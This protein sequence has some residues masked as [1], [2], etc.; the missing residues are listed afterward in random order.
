MP[1]ARWLLLLPFAAPLLY[2]GPAAELAKGIAQAGLDPQSCYRVRDL[3]LAKE[4]LRLYF[5][6]GYLIFGKPIDGDPIT[7]VF[8]TTLQGGDA[9]IMALPPN[10]GERQSLASFTHS[11]NLDEHF[12]LAVMLFTDQTYRD[13]LAQ[14]GD[15][16]S[17][18]KSPEMGLTMAPEWTPVVRNLASSFENRLVLDLLSG[19][20]SSQAFFF[21]AIAG[22]ELGNFDA[23]YDARSSEQITLGHSAWRDERPYFDVWTSFEARAQRNGTRAA[24]KPEFDVDDFR[25][26]A[27]LLPPDLRVQAVT[28]VKV[29]PA[30]G[31]GRVFPFELSRSMRVTAASVDGRPAEIFEAESQR[32]NLIHDRGNGLILLIP[33]QPLTPGREYEFE[34]HHEGAVIAT[35]GNKVYA[36]G[37]RANWYP[38]RGLHFTKFDL[39]FRYPKDLDLVSSGDVVSDVVEGDSRVT[40][41]KV[42]TPV[43]MVGFN[44][45]VYDREKITRGSQTVEV[46]AN[47]SLERAL[48]PR[49]VTP[50]PIGPPQP[51]ARGRNRLPPPVSGVSG[52]EAPTVSAPAARLRELASDVASALEFMSARFGPPPLSTLTVSP[53]PGTFGQGFPGLIYLSTL[54]YLGPANKPIVGLRE[55]DKLF[56][57]EMLYAHE[58]AHQWWGNLVGSAGYPHD[59]LLE[60]LANYSAL[61]Y[62]EK[63]KGTRA[64]ES[65]LG[66]YR[67]DLMAKADGGRTLESAGPIALGLRLESSLNPKAWRAI[68]YEKGT[69]I[70]HMLRRR[71]GDERFDAFL[72]ELRRRFEWKLLDTESFRLLAAEFLP[73][74]SPDP[75]L[76]SFFDQWVYGTGIPAL[77]MTSSLSGKV[78]A[79]KLTVT[80]EQTG[81]DDEFSA[82][83]PVEIQFRRAK[84][85]T[86]VVRTSNEPAVFT[87]PVPQPPAK[88]ALDPGNSVLAVKR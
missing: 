27:T 4:D 80:V 84:T 69:W 12:R 46:C 1:C 44:L 57:S 67:D 87:I 64:T 8:V 32:S 55:S 72:G 15:N 52:D 37:S 28:R 70:L 9:E 19:P 88:V 30:G 42:A 77:R 17:N 68:V 62:L 78:P 58:T 81:V 54:S 56:F 83:V 48:L 7:A 60:A 82:A 26:S 61:L 74:K 18:K 73:P 43:R 10:R 79:L 65:I 40:R 5:T 2:A 16:P 50:P 31:S 14:I 20:R 29:T 11:P 75:K 25:I 24:P 47:R 35:A 21:A 66:D 76:D 3:T 49:P 36:V 63:H 85:I 22:K 45:G 23:L 53:S 6:D 59:W 13:L 51:A 41:R 38:N 33:P 86:R 71:M 34:F 39:T